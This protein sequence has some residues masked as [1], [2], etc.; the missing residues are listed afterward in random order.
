M[1]TIAKQ[2]SQ[3][4]ETLET[5]LAKFKRH[6]NYSSTVFHLLTLN[7]LSSPGTEKGGRALWGW[8]QLSS[9][10]FPLPQDDLKSLFLF[11]F[12]K[13]LPVTCPYTFNYHCCS[14]PTSA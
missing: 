4:I 3:K 13:F 6:R 2:T 8:G 5:F 10:Q 7:D 14:S 11:E 12:W 1:L 9:P